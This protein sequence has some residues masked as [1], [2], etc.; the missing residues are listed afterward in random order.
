MQYIEGATIRE[1]MQRMVTCGPALPI[2]ETVFRGVA[3]VDRGGVEIRFDEPTLSYDGQTEAR[4]ATTEPE[5]LPHGAKALI[6]SPKYIQRCVQIARDVALALAHAHERGVVHRDIKPENV[7]VGESGTVHLIDFGLARSF[8]DLTWTNTGALLGTPRY[9]S[10]EQV[11]G[12][13]KVDHRTDIY[14]LGFMLYE[15]LTSRPPFAAE[16]RESLLR[17]IVAKALPPV[18]WRNRSVPRDLEAVVHKATAKDP[19]DR[20]QTAEEFAVD[21]YRVIDGCPVLAPR[22]R[23]RLDEAEIAAERPRT[24][25]VLGFACFFLGVF[26]LA[27]SGILFIQALSESAISTRN[28]IPLSLPAMLGVLGLASLVSTRGLL[29]ARRWAPPVVAG[30]FLLSALLPSSMVWEVMGLYRFGTNVY[31]RYWPADVFIALSYAAISVGFILA[32]VA[33]F[34]PR[35]RAWLRLAQNVR[36]EHAR[37]ASP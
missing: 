35:I 9:M 23:F 33:L 28:P 13:I 4:P 32:G 1:I 21:L 10:P 3:S 14:S 15:M 7:V 37:H 19:D 18:S 29:A 12:R 36:S 6:G 34:Q 8:E 17:Q 24:V 30:I 20:Y 31:T 26:A 11:T 22:Y 16:T 25:T 27:G 2:T 5:E